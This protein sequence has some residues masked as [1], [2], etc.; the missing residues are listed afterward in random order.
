MGWAE[1]NLPEGFAVFDYPSGHRT[2]L[3]TTNGLECINRVIKHKTRTALIFPNAAS[4][5]R[6]VSALI[7]E[8]DEVWMTAKIY[9]TM[10]A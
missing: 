6:L 8:C 4:C 3:P 10:K 5:L 9:L 7:A 1:A 2:R